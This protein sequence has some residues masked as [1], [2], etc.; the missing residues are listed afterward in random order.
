M[1]QVVSA[2]PPI[3]ENATVEN[4]PMAAMTINAPAYQSRCAASNVAEGATALDGDRLDR[5]ARSRSRSA[6]PITPALSAT[7]RSPSEYNIAAN[8]VF[9]WPV[10]PSASMLAP[11]RVATV[12]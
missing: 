9:Q 10:R 2:R 6:A 5:N 8:S 11:G 1:A 3:C 4:R 7:R 12:R